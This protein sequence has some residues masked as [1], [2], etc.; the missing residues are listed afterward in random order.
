MSAPRNVNATATD[1]SRSVRLR[2]TVIGIGIGALARPSLTAGTI[3]GALAATAGFAIIDSIALGV[4][5]TIAGVLAVVRWHH[6]ATLVQAITL[7]TGRMRVAAD[8]ET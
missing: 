1:F 2:A 3:A 4:L 6:H 7:G 5:A 8:D